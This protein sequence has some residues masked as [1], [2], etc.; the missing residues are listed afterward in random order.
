MFHHFFTC[1]LGD[2]GHHIGLD[3]HYSLEFERGALFTQMYVRY[4]KED[5]LIRILLCRFAGGVEYP[6]GHLGSI[7]RAMSAFSSRPDIVSCTGC[8]LSLL[9]LLAKS[10]FCDKGIMRPLR[11]DSV[12]LSSLLPHPASC[13]FG[14]IPFQSVLQYLVVFLGGAR[15]QPWILES[16]NLL[17]VILSLL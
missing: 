2:I 7:A 9:E 17:K 16:P 14:N 1:A 5:R 15:Q 8:P 4:W 3:N 10:S 6:K 11:T 13:V 12:Q